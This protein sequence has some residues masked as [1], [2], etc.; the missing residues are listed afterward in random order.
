MVFPVKI[1]SVHAIVI[2]RLTEHNC[3]T[4]GKHVTKPQKTQEAALPTV[5]YLP[6]SCLIHINPPSTMSDNTENIIKAS[7]SMKP[8]E[9]D[10]SVLRDVFIFIVSASMLIGLLALGLELARQS[11]KPPNIIIILADDLGELMS[12]K[13][14]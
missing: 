13:F 6:F 1:P 5:H 11:A 3:G 10:K 2:P 14:F 12:V 9:M 4:L 8:K 7:T